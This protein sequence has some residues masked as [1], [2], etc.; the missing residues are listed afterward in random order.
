[1]TN[2]KII[3][4]NLISIAILLL[5]MA[6]HLYLAE[7]GIQYIQGSGG[8]FLYAK[9]DFFGPHIINMNGDES[10]SLISPSILMSILLFFDFVFLL[11]YKFS[12]QI[13]LNIFFLILTFFFYHKFLNDLNSSL[14]VAVRSN[15]FWLRELN[16]F[17]YE[18]F[19]N[20][21]KTD[22]KGYNYSVFPIIISII[23][24]ASRL[25]SRKEIPLQKNYEI[26]TLK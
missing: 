22:V 19:D 14:E 8:G 18:F 10:R 7:G 25:F 13:L 3:Y 12:K 11:K 6:L 1:M 24:N 4:F 17:S 23:Y 5:Y 15:S 20:I 9:F 21:E 26:D 2:K 16:F